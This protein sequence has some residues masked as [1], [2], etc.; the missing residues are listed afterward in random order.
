MAAVVFFADPGHVRSKAYLVFA[1]A[2]APLDDA[3]QFFA[4]N[5][6]EAEKHD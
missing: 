3:L 5:P 2:S 1:I 6:G 4:Q